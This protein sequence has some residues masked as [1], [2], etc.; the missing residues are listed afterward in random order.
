MGACTLRTVLIGAGG[1]ASF[2]KEHIASPFLL[3]AVG[4]RQ[5]VCPIPSD[6]DLYIIAVSDSAIASVAEELNEVKGL[7]VH[8]AGSVPM[9]VL[10]NERRGVFYPLQTISRG[11]SIDPSCVPF[12][13]EASQAQDMDLL[14][15]LAESFGSNATPMDSERR[16]HLHLGAVFCCNFVNR[17]YAIAADF[18]AGQDIPFSALLPLIHETAHK[19]DTLAPRLAQTGPAVR[20]DRTVM[21]QQMDLLRDPKN[22]EI[23]ELL[24]QSIYDDKLR[25]EKD[26]G[27]LS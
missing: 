3:T 17:L 1:V 19:V 2:L 8:T 14:R 7:V 16:R 21:Q 24:S 20:N 25:F 18:L 4:G 13:I 26:K 15:Q 12:Y 23:Y 6:A 9:D 5:R 11:R 10:C 22:K 27:H